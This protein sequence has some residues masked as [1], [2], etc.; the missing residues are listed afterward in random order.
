MQA[1][2]RLNATLYQSIHN[3]EL[4]QWKMARQL[5]LDSSDIPVSPLGPLTD[6]DIM[7]M[8]NLDSAAQPDEEG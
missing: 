6:A 7:S 1:S 3:M 5:N 4:L 8:I 2:C